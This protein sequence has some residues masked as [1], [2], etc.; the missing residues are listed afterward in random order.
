[1]LAG[2]RIGIEEVDDRIRPVGC[3]TYDLGYVD[4]EQHLDNP[5]GTRSSHMSPGRDVTR[6]PGLGKVVVAERGDATMRDNQR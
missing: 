6:V 1:M 2:Q 5:F 3:M 4:L